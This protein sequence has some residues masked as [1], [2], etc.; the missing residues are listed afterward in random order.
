M[1][2]YSDVL[3]SK[4]AFK[5]NLCRYEAELSGA[6]EMDR[7]SEYGQVQAIIEAGPSTSRM[8]LTHELETT[9]LPGDPTL[10]TEM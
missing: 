8:Q 6:N 9:W 1:N 7:N 10:E 5:C 2:L 3:V 4:F